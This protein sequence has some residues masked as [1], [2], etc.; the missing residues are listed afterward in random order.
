MKKK[1]LI[2][3]VAIGLVVGAIVPSSAF[4]GGATIFA[5]LCTDIGNDTACTSPTGVIYRGKSCAN[6]VPDGCCQ[7][8]TYNYDCPGSPGLTIIHK[9]WNASLPWPLSVTWACV[10]DTCK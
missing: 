8:K 7:Y 5:S 4:A 10:G 3:L 1:K 9:T 2:S 6:T